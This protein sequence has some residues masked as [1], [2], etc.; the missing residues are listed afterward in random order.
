MSNQFIESLAQEMVEL[1]IEPSDIFRFWGARLSDHFIFDLPNPP[2]VHIGQ[3]LNAAVEPNATS[4]TRTTHARTGDS[5]GDSDCEYH[6]KFFAVKFSHPNLK[7]VHTD[8]IET[9]TT[10]L[11]AYRANPTA[12]NLKALKFYDNFALGELCRFDLADGYSLEEQRALRKADYRRR[13]DLSAA[14][15]DEISHFE[16]VTSIGDLIEARKKEIGRK[17][18]TW[19]KS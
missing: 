4:Q 9:L 2:I 15:S 3:P 5:D 14:P 17:R 6:P 1:G 13:N 8:L 11:D 18:N 7:T 10:L 19:R 16:S 12:S